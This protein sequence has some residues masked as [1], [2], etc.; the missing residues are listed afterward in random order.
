MYSEVTLSNGRRSHGG[1]DLK[2]APRVRAV[3][4]DMSVEM[5]DLND[6]AENCDISRDDVEL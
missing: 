2:A 4:D 5:S 1:K 3:F 6:I